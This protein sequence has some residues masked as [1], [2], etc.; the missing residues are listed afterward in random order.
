MPSLVY[1]IVLF[2][3]SD[4]DLTLPSFFNFLPRKRQVERSFTGLEVL[5]IFSGEGIIITARVLST[6]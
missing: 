2:W 1:V 3:V 5:C 4:E 6:H